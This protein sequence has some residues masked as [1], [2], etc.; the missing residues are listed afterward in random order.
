[1]NNEILTFIIVVILIVLI[2]IHQR[3]VQ[4]KKQYFN[5][6]NINNTL[7]EISNQLSQFKDIDELYQKML[8]YTIKLIKGAQYGSI[9]IYDKINDRMD[10]KVLSG[11]DISEISCPYLKK[12]ELFLYSLNKLS[13]PGIIVNPL[14]NSRH[15]SK[16]YENE[17]LKNSKQ[18]IYKS[19]LS[20]PLNIDSEFFGCIS[21]DNIETTTAFSKKDIEIIKY[22]SVYLEIVIKNML[23]MNSMKERLITD[24]LTGLLNRRYYNNMVE[25][26]FNNRKSANTTFIMIDIDS[27]KTINDTYGHHAGDEVLKY[28]ADL[29]RSRFGRGDSIIRYAGD[30]FLLA[31]Y[32]WGVKDAERILTG[33]KDELSSNPFHGIKISFSYGISELENE[34]EAEEVIRKAD[35]NM[36]MQKATKK[37]DCKECVEDFLQQKT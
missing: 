29:L 5:S 24:S 3:Y 33:I 35:L 36:Y 22:I 23:L 2:I 4:V 37:L 27:F 31:L 18:L 6:L 15:S 8:E 21:V 10:F 16:P 14:L 28:F 9:I 34:L 11:Y 30:E 12:E 32:E 7:I 25:C 1:M 19:V 20:A 13:G 17:I 26:N